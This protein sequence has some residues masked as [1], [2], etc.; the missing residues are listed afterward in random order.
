MHENEHGASGSEALFQALLEPLAEVEKVLKEYKDVVDAEDAEEIR[1]TATSLR[2]RGEDLCVDGRLLRL[3]IVG[4]VKAGKSSLLNALLFGDEEVLPQAATPMTAS[5]TH[6]VTSDRDEVEVE[7]YS[8]REWDDIE[9]H[10]ERYRVELE[11]C[12]AVASANPEPG[13]NLG[14]DTAS[15]SV[16]EPAE[17]L[18]AS[19]E[20]SKMAKDK[21]I[22]VRD[23]LGTKAK[24][25]APVDRLNTMLRDLVGAEGKLT[26]LVKSVT[27][28][29]SHGIP[30]MDI[31][32]T[33]GINDPIKSR[34]HK[35]TT[36]LGRCDAV[37]LLS[38]AGQFMDAE[39]VQFFESRTRAQGI[40]RKVLLGSKFDS[41]LID[42]SRDHER[43]LQAARED[44]SVRLVAHALRAL[45]QARGEDDIG[46]SEKDILFVSPM[47]AS[48]ARRP[49]G[50]WSAVEREVFDNLQRAYPDWL[51]PVGSDAD[52][53]TRATLAEIG[54]AGSV[55]RCIKE[56]RRD[57]D[58][59]M[60]ARLGDFLKVQRESLEEA[61]GMLGEDLGAAR[62][63]L[64]SGSIADAEKLKSLK[65][66]LEEIGEKVTDTWEDLV[67]AEKKPIE[68]AAQRIREEARKAKALI[69]DAVTKEMR[70]RLVDEDG[71]GAWFARKLWGGG[72]RQESYSVKVEDEAAIQDAADYL[73]EETKVHFEEAV[74][75]MFQAKF[76]DDSRETMCRLVADGLSSE[77][78]AITLDPA[79]MYRSIRKAVDRVR[80]S[81]RDSLKGVVSWEME[82][83]AATPAALVPA[84]EKLNAAMTADYDSPAKKGREV[85]TAL[86]GL[87]DACADYTESKVEEVTQRARTDLLPAISSSFEA[88]HNRLETDQADR[89]VRQQRYQLALEAVKNSLLRLSSV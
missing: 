57:K 34:S 46:V 84:L 85:V 17:F 11:Q 13:R 56:V 15:S 23:Y 78:A 48:L 74:N 25:A 6:I 32:D 47:C 65:H 83:E 1:R 14:A 3:G 18:R 28:R 2:E 8:Q 7:Y 20:L 73:L 61:L 59:I 87:A 79:E 52:E 24:H 50:T 12:E 4:Q 53:N 72:K 88:E 55:D 62:E 9:R 54:N 29:C 89:E 41:A 22:R 70:T 71:V 51:D 75:K 33:P 10:A 27:I 66:A 42:V 19:H 5:L 68:K 21:G 82:E 31:V 35:T 67:G 37:L 16:A 63:R 77:Q 81:A 40:K 44:T 30:D 76:R 80:R 26:P 45:R 43:D 38:Y 58:S 64:T 69:R 39:D 36:L 86:G 60:Q 49:V